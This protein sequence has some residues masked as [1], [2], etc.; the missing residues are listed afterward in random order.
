MIRATQSISIYSV[1]ITV[2]LLAS[3]KNAD[4]LDVSATSELIENSRLVYDQKPANAEYRLV[5]SSLKKING[6]WVGRSELILDGMLAR[7]TYELD[8]LLRF[9]EARRMLKKNVLEPNQ[10][11]IVFTCDGLDCG[12]SN[13]WANQIFQIKQLYG[14]DNYQVY[15]V[16]REDDTANIIYLVQRGNQRTYLQIDTLKIDEDTS[17]ALAEVSQENVIESALQNNGY[18]IV[19]H[20]NETYEPHKGLAANV[21]ALVEYIKLNPNSKIAVVGHSSGRSALKKSERYAE[22][23]YR[24]L[25]AANVESKNVEVFAAGAFLPRANAPADRIEVVLMKP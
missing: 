20:N 2:I 15:T 18:W 9:S 12:S 14:L 25:M 21:S 1:L 19:E 5:T 4:A 17:N 16:I 3:V 8:S 22:K 6:R 11:N 23:F 24:D 10:D 13:A 7:K